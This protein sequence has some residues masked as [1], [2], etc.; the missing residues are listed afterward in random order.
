[1]LSITPNFLSTLILNPL[2]C[3]EVWLSRLLKCSLI[4]LQKTPDQVRGLIPAEPLQAK[5]FLCDFQLLFCRSFNFFLS[6][7]IFWNLRDKIQCAE[8]FDLCRRLGVADLF[9]GRVISAWVLP[10]CLATDILAGLKA[11]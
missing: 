2:V 9:K 11:H 10:L 1:M 7:G 8:D 3:L 6:Q 4:L 5:A